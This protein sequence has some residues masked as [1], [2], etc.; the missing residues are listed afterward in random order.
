MVSV[1]SNGSGLVKS[2]IFRVRNSLPSSRL[3]TANVEVSDYHIDLEPAHTILAQ[4]CLGVLL[5]VQ[6]DVEGCTPE[7][8]PLAR[9]A[10]EHWTAHAQF[11]YVSSR[12]RKGMEYLFDPD[13]PH[14]KT[15]ITL[16]D[17]DT[18]PI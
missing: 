4:A 3:A 18:S 10:S 1:E 5:Q 8:H 17:V 16:Y 13:R 15:W 7:D 14:F 9:Y 6:D 12:L 2:R 11:E